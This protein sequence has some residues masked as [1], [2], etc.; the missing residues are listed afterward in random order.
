MS[1]KRTEIIRLVFERE[2]KEAEDINKNM[3]KDSFSKYRVMPGAKCW[4]ST[5][6]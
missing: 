4:D 2:N 6:K 3:I 1:P 5:T